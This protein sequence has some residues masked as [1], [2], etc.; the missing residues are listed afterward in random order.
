MSSVHVGQVFEDINGFKEALR[1]WAIVG[2][3]EYRWAFSDSQ[4]C[5]AVC[6]HKTCNFTVQC[7]AYPAK[8]CAKVTVLVPD[9]HCAGN[10]L[11]GQAQASR[12][13]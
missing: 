2:H 10:A 4:R 8:E 1:N 12:L 11:V 9:H 7:N 6:V 5:K 3:F 13:D